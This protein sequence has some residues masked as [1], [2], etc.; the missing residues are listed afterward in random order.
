[1]RLIFIYGAVASGKLTVARELGC[2]AALPVFHNHL[3]VDGLS[4]VFPF[5]TPAFIKLRESFWLAVMREAARDGRSIIFTFAPE[6]T[7]TDGFPETARRTVQEAG[8]ETVFVRLTV[9]PDVQENRLNEPSRS[10]FGKMGS[11]E[12]L[13]QLRA[14][15]DICENRMPS[16]AFAIDTTNLT[17]REA[18]VLIANRLGLPLP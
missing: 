3:I 14:A 1:M 2:L 12:Q 9:D 4:A 5:G 17:P 15:F 10:E 11:V 18:A 13:R 8:G 7:V 6:P 16:A